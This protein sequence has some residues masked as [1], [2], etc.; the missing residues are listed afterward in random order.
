[1]NE[2]KRQM[3]NESLVRLAP[4]ADRAVELFHSR[5][6]ELDPTLRYMFRGDFKQQGRQ[7]IETIQWLVN[8]LD[9]LEEVKPMIRELGRRHADFGVRDEHYPIICA[10]LIWTLDG[11]LGASFTLETRQAWI[12][13]Y[14]EIAGTMQDA[15]CEAFMF[16]QSIAQMERRRKYAMLQYG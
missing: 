8:S 1:M 4:T 13:L 12:E 15:A 3:I 6:Y 5:L 10:A 9:R 11:G 7:F 16:R 14:C 2:R